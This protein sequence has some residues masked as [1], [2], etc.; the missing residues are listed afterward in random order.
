MELWKY[1]TPAATE[2]FF[3]RMHLAEF[4]IGM[5]KYD[6]GDP[7]LADFADNLDLFHDIGA[8]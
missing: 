3:D 8:E 1:K 2:F 5:L 7:R 6:W 4:N